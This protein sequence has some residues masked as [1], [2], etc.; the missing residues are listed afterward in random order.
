MAV[1]LLAPL[2]G[3]LCPPTGALAA[4]AEEAYAD[5]NFEKAGEY[6][7]KALEKNPD[8]A[9]LNFNIGNISYKNKQYDDA[10]ASF[11]HALQSDDLALQKKAYYNLGNAHFRKG[12]TLQ[13]SNL[14]KTKE[15]WQDALKAYSSSLQ[16]NPDHEE[17]RFNHDFV[18]KKLKELLE[19]ENQQQNQQGNSEKKQQNNKDESE[20]QNEEQQAGEQQNSSKE[21]DQTQPSAQ[22]EMEKQ[23]KQN[24]WTLWNQRGWTKS[25]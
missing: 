20:K 4:A 5:N 16:L 18:E 14:Q 1:A 25:E 24:N 13:Q 11:N 21:T 23:D 17:A 12:E 6:Y 7:E 10:I 2:L 15:H 8:S 9:V 3:L 19:Q 22:Q